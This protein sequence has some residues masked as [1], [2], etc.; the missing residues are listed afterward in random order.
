MISSLSPFY[1]LSRTTSSISIVD[2]TPSL[3]VSQFYLITYITMSL[4]VPSSSNKRSSLGGGGSLKIKKKQ[5]PT[6]QL[7]EAHGDKVLGSYVR[8]E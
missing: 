3:I 2:D 4:R 6:I 8:S 7:K 5:T 1:P